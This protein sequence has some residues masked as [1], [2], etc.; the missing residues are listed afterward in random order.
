MLKCFCSA[1]GRQC[2]CFYLYISQPHSYIYLE[3]KQVMA[4]SGCNP[5]NNPFSGDNLPLWGVPGCF[6]GPPIMNIPVG[7]RGTNN[8]GG[9]PVWYNPGAPP[10]NNPGWNN[11][12]G[13]F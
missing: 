5:S 12:R 9:P 10:T 13:A 11:G 2:Y 1:S 3:Q 6:G 7:P 8:P 4:S